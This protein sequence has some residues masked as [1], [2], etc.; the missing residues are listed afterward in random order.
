MSHTFVLLKKSASE[1]CHFVSGAGPNHVVKI[2]L[3]KVV[4]GSG[5]S[6]RLHGDVGPAIFRVL[7][8]WVLSGENCRRFAGAAAALERLLKCLQGE[9]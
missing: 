7:I 1:N 8:D 9:S 3:D 2:E 5:T 6:S 4:L